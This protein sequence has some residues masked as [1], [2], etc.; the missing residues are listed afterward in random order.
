MED[1]HDWQQ[2][3]DEQQRYEEELEDEQQAAFQGEV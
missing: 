1:N 3:T 2:M